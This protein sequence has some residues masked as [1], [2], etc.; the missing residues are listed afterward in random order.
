MR[1]R[2]AASVLPRG[3]PA[4]AGYDRSMAG[5]ATAQDYDVIVIGSEIIGCAIAREV[6]RRGARTALFEARAIG[7]GAT[8]ASAGV[9]APF[10]EAPGEGPLQALT[11][12]SLAM[13]D[14]FVASVAQESN[15]T[16]EYRRCGTLEIAHDE[17]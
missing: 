6:S 5:L 4:C 11:V 14:E 1:R 16:I 8:Q 7:A 13:Y 2:N 10:I 12:E 3:R 17:A 15:T 9:L